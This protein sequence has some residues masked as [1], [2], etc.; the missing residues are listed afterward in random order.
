M[1]KKQPDLYDLLGVKSDASVDEI[2]QAFKEKAK[3]VHPD[4]GGSE[5]EF[6]VLNEA[7]KTLID[8]EKRIAYD[9]TGEILT[10]QEEQTYLILIDYLRSI[11]VESVQSKTVISIHN[12]IHGIK[13]SI[14][15]LEKDLFDIEGYREAVRKSLKGI[16]HKRTRKS[17]IN[18]FERARLNIFEELKTKE[19]IT[20][21]KIS[22][23]KKLIELL[24]T[25]ENKDKPLYIADRDHYETPKRRARL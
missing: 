25:Y 9:I 15:K 2:K 8:N 1:M 24:N 23:S 16:K 22:E 17:K 12:L 20:K 19:Q 11:I 14:A 6:K 18:C 21:D 5:E 10:P 7:Y 3:H 13:K 4:A